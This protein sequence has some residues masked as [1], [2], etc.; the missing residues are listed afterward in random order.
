MKKSLFVYLIYVKD[1]PTPNMSN[2]DFVLNENNNQSDLQKEQDNVNNNASKLN[3]CLKTYASCFT[4]SIPN[5]L[6]PP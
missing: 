1:P 5:E 6:H 3:D 2:N 4:D